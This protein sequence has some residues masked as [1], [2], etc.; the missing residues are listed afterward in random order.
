MIT[1]HDLTHEHL[2]TAL[3]RKKHNAEG[4]VSYNQVISSDLAEELDNVVAI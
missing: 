4:D 2:H 1:R 3:H